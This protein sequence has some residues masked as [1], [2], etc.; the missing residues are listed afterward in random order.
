MQDQV[1]RHRA[2]LLARAADPA[3]RRPRR[4]PGAGARGAARHRPRDLAE[5]PAVLGQ[6]ARARLLH[7]TDA[8]HPREP[9][10]RRPHPRRLGGDDS[11]PRALS[12]RAVG[13]RPRAGPLPLGRRRR[14]ADGAVGARRG[15]H[16][17]PERGAAV[18]ERD[19]DLARARAQQRRLHRR[20]AARVHVLRPAE[21]S[22]AD[23]ADG[24]KGGRRHAG[25]RLRRG[26][27][28]LPGDRGVERAAGVGRRAHARP[29]RQP[30]RHQPD[31]ADAAHRRHPRRRIVPGRRADGGGAALSRDERVRS[32]ADERLVPLLRAAD[33]LHGDRADGRPH[34]RRHPRHDHRRPL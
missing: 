19:D 30:V 10:D 13:R 12:V 11:R 7:A 20:P 18:H 8:A 16:R 2:V 17:V 4:L 6:R 1:R 3:D 28:R 31:D 15:R 32:A 33:Q 27:R 22:G 25:H 24:R 23:H 29:R 21:T 5:R 26:L 34:R 9:G 14:P